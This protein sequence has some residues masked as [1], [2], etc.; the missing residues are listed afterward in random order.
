MAKGEK[1]MLIDARPYMKYLQGSIPSAIGIPE[2]EFAAK[3][4]MLPVDK[5]N[6]TLVYFCGGYKCALSH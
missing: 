1:Y 4:G 2:K 5:E 6:V 3:R